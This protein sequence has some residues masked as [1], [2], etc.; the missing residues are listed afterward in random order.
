MPSGRSA[1]MAMTYDIN[2]TKHTGGK[3]AH[4]SFISTRETWSFVT[5]EGIVE[6]NDEDDKRSQL[7]R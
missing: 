1:A 3:S 2:V 6:H 4:V 5:V 7:P